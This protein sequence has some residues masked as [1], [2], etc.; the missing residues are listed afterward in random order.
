MVRR[1]V[2]T[3]KESGPIMAERETPFVCARF[4]TFNRPLMSG[5]IRRAGHLLEEQRECLET[6]QRRSCFVDRQ[7][8]NRSS[9]DEKQRRSSLLMMEVG[10]TGWTVIVFHFHS[11]NGRRLV[12]TQRTLI[13][14]VI[15]TEFV[16]FL[17]PIIL[18]NLS[19]A[20]ANGPS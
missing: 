17:H 16:V 11:T 9:E 8:M 14:L 5:P 7:E 6:L 20:E 13:I 2:K 3:R 1:L 19:S 12:P 18:K 4:S 15:V 10:G